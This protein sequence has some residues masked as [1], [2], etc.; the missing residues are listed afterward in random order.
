M[1]KTGG[2]WDTRPHQFKKLGGLLPINDAYDEYMKVSELFIS[3][4]D[5]RM[6]VCDYRTKV[7]LC[8]SPGV[9][10]LGGAPPRGRRGIV[11]GA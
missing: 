6:I 8:F 7:K 2:A 1:K 9:L 4:N 11:G 5:S 10:K 3:T